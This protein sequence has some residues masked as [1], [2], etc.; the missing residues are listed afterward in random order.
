[1]QLLELLPHADGM[2]ADLAELRAASAHHL[3]LH[4][5]ADG[6][7]EPVLLIHAAASDVA[8]EAA[9]EGARVYAL[10]L[11]VW[12]GA[13]QSIMR[14]GETL[15]LDTVTR[16]RCCLPAPKVPCLRPLCARSKAFAFRFCT[17]QAHLE[18]ALAAA[19]LH[20]LLHLG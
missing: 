1:M 6:S 19:S 2:V 14:L 10:P 9:A 20:L 13:L 12:S 4:D 3:L 8:S 17:S 16:V 7:T 18:A 11:Q 5:A 15:Q